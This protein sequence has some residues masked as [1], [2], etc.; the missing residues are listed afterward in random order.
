MAKINFLV[1]P[2][3]FETI[4]VNGREYVKAERYKRAVEALRKVASSDNETARWARRALRDL[5]EDGS[6]E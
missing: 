3:S 4:S 2:D 6:G 5:G 1:D